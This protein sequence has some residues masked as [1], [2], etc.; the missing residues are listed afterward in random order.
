M[1][2]RPVLLSSL[3]TNEVLNEWYRSVEDYSRR[4]L[5]FEADKLPA[6]SGYAHMIQKHV[7][8]A[9]L[10]GIWE[11]DLLTGLLWH[12]SSTPFSTCSQLKKPSH[13]RAPSWSWA[14]LDG[15]ISY[16]WTWISHGRPQSDL[17]LKAIKVQVKHR[18]SDSMG[19]VLAGTLKVSSR[20]KR[21]TWLAPENSAAFWA[22]GH[23]PTS[24]SDLKNWNILR[25]EN[26]DEMNMPK[27]KEGN[28][29]TLDG[30]GLRSD[31]EVR[32]EV[33]QNRHKIFLQRQKRLNTIAICLFDTE[34][35]CP[36]NVWCL[37]VAA[38]RGLV[39]EYL[40]ERNVFQRVGFYMSSDSTWMSKSPISTITIV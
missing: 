1:G 23:F 29:T 6:L 10:A 24:S 27:E 12:A 31:P 19:Q 14:A 7:G 37:A 28:L 5:T 18:G 33:I 22:R 15:R 2:S 3:F 17:W 25:T 32:S 8:G 9:Y 35:V 34:D 11:S 38:E 21:A 40:A 13:Q 30:K 36:K 4:D 26:G 20:L 16:D 39:L